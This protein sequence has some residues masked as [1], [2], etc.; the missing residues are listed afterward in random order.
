MTNIENIKNKI[1]V[2]DYDNSK[3]SLNDVC[4][5]TWK[6]DLSTGTIADTDITLISAS[7]SYCVIGVALN[8]INLPEAEF[9]IIQ[10]LKLFC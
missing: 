3:L 4:A 8:S 9:I 2:V 6:K 1:F 5:Q 10:G 7:D